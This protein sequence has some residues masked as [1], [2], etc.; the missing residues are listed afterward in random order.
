MRTGFLIILSTA[1]L[2]SSCK[3]EPR[4]DNVVEAREESRAILSPKPD[5]PPLSDLVTSFIKRK[6]EVQQQLESVSPEEANALYEAY[7]KEN[8]KALLTIEEAER[9]FLDNYY[10]YFYTNESREKPVH[11][12]INQKINLLKKAGLEVWDIGEGMVEIRAIPEFYRD[13]FGNYVTEEYREFISMNA[14]EDKVL[15]AADAGIGISWEELG[16]RVINWENFVRKYPDSKL[17]DRAKANYR[18]YQY[19]YLFGMDNTP[20][21]DYQA[22]TLYPENAE[23]FN[24]FIK[25]YPE[26]PTAKIAQQMLNNNGKG[27]DA[28]EQQM[29]KEFEAAYNIANK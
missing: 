15:W 10:G 11:D 4:E 16:E 3:N 8:A 20:T 17:A 25:E 6:G 5:A 23:E 18:L 7:T 29:Q 13:L 28:L 19:S 27:F 9:H 21:Y 26:S 22:N 24:R 2:I 1:L 14:E 12:S